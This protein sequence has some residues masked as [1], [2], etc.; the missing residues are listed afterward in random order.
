MLRNQRTYEMPSAA[1]G[2]ITSSVSVDEG[3]AGYFTHANEGA[4]RHAR[5]LWFQ[6]GADTALSRSWKV[7]GKRIYRLYREE[8]LSLR[9]KTPKR[10]VSCRL[11][12]DRPEAIR[13]NDCQAMD[14]MTDELFDGR[15]IRLL[16]IVNHFTRESPAIVVGQRLRC[17]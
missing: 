7:N 2:T 4:D 17:R 8:N 1:A 11:R 14:F 6:A 9:T 15:R 3:R 12:N 5:S 13:I 10:R 16:T